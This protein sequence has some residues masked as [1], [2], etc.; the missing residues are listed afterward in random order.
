MLSLNAQDETGSCWLSAFNEVGEKIIGRPA[1]ELAQMKEA[2]EE[3]RLS[4]IFQ[5]AC[6][7][8]WQMKLVTKADQYQDKWRLRTTV[9]SAERFNYEEGCRILR[10]KI[11]ELEGE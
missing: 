5:D 4:F 6:Y 3:Q 8:R 10:E 9:L 11:R 2:G 7:T 1:S